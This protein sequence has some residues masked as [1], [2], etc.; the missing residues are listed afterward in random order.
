MKYKYWLVLAILIAAAAFSGCK[1][2]DS[3][4]SAQE[5]NFDKDASYALGM[6]IG[7]SL[8]NS[9]STDGIVPNIDEFIK[10][11]KDSL[12]GKETRFDEYEAMD[13]IN[14][15]FEALSEGKNAEAVQKENAFLAENSRKSGVTIT[16]SGLQYEIVTETNGRKPSST[17][18]VRVH[19]EGRLADGTVFDSSIERGTPA[20]FPL[21]G[22]ISGWTEGLQLMGVGSKYIFYV[23]SELGYGPG[24]WGPIPPYAT[25]I[26]NVELL[27]ILN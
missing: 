21:N 19:Y 18:T 2:S 5:E 12:T 16:P 15:A 1:G 26:F 6:S 4:S 14:S 7:G 11:L 17:D 20:E 23:P 25:L 13:I 24:G 3:G 9:L 22:V 10:G 27:D 8:K